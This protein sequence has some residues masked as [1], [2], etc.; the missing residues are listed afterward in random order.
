MLFDNPSQ[1]VHLSKVKKLSA[2]S[3]DFVA[4]VEE[5]Y[6]VD[7]KTLEISRAAEPEHEREPYKGPKSRGSASSSVVKPCPDGCKMLHHKG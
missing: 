5:H 4:W 7:K 6:H 3:A 1:Y 2:E